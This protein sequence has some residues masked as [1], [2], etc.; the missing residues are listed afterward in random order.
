MLFIYFGIIFLVFHFNIWF[1]IETHIKTYATIKYKIIRFRLKQRIKTVF[2]C[3]ILPGFFILNNKQNTQINYHYFYCSP[4]EV[5]HTILL[6]QLQYRL[7]F[8]YFCGVE[9]EVEVEV[10]FFLSLFFFIVLITFLIRYLYFLM[11]SRLSCSGV[12]PLSRFLS[13][14]MS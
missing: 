3:S 7:L 9:V 13:T 14:Y 6:E 5:F 12:Y 4:I 11:K 8:N 1:Y 10:S 2:T